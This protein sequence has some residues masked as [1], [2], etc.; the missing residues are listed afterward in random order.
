LVLLP[1]A[2]VLPTDE[3]GRLL[4]V[5]QAD[6]GL[7][8][9]IGGSVEPEEAPQEAAVREALEEAGVTVKLLGVRAVLGGPDFTVVYPNGDQCAYVSTVFDAVVVSGEPRADGD[10]TIEVRWFRPEELAD[11]EMDRCNRA[12]L[13][14]CGIL[15]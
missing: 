3:A 5:R 1:A 9:T 14:G 11:L 10:E 13:M 4:L 6:H 12:I 7:W 15:I 8:A 2:A